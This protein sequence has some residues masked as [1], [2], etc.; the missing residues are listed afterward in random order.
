MPII[1]T[2]VDGRL[3]DQRTSGPA[4]QRTKV[5]GGY[6]CLAVFLAVVLVFVLIPVLDLV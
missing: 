3:A 6:A 1:A 2:L 5:R 4:D